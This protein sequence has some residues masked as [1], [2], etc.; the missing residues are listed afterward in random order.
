MATMKQNTPRSRKVSIR[1]KSRSTEKA[2]P[3]Q[4][5]RAGRP[6]SP[7][8]TRDA[9]AE[10]ALSIVDEKGL[11]GLSL[12]A[13][14]QKMGV[15][16]PSLYYHFRDKEELLVKVSRL[17]LKKIS[18][19]RDTWSD[20]WE[21]RTKELA[22]ATYRVTMRHPNAAPIA[23]RFFPRAVVQPA[24]ERTLASC[25]YKPEHH[26]VVLEAIE[27]FTFGYTIFAAA[28]ASL[29]TPATPTP[30]PE[31]Y[32]FLAQALKVAPGSDEEIFT[33]ALQVILDGLRVRYG[34]G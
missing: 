5:N 17:L 32:P 8:I 18:S 9:A 3:A 26:I 16:A 31:T 15:R 23:L 27:R 20:D 22:L 2:S 24:Y 25:P 28:A 14:A 10:A 11:D 21:A 29:H 19:E 34:K 12:Q 13:V 30:D 7:L 6:A 33:E 1:G 4:S